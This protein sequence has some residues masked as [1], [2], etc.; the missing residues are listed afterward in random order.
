MLSYL[1]YVAVRIT[2]CLFQVLS[3]ETC[4]EVSRFL[5]KVCGQWIGF[6]RKL[7]DQ[8]LQC[9]FPEMPAPQRRELALK[10]WEHLIL[11]TAETAHCYRKIN[12]NNWR[13]YVELSGHDVLLRNLLNE[14]PLILVSAHF[15]NFEL[16]GFVT[17]ILGFQTHTVARQ[18]DNPY[19]HD[20]VTRFRSATGQ[21]IVPKKGGFEQIEQILDRGQTLTLLADQYAGTKGCWVQFFNRPA[22]VHKAIA[23]LAL[24][25]GAMVAVGEAY[26]IGKPL[27]YRINL[28]S[29]IDSKQFQ[30]TPDGP[31]QLT[32][33]FTTHLEHVIR[34]H[35]DQYWWLHDRWKDRRH[36]HKKPKRVAA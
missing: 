12:Q 15:G 24:E 33:W 11:F 29:V 34:R 10:M 30:D 36:L 3:I 32:Q 31:R 27:R 16:A 2:L 13:D 28:Q 18:L 20:F 1:G 35:P 22:S 17:G 8:N 7:I 21:H 14:R 25:H 23:L 26:R 9:A 4:Q 19:L 5:A 6:R